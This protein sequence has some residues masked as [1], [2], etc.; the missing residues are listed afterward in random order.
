MGDPIHAVEILGPDIR[1]VHVKDARRP[2]IPG[3]WGEEVPLGQGEVDIPR[4]LRT[5]KADRLR[6]PAG[7][8]ARGRRP[9][10]ADPRRPA[11]PRPASADAW[12]SPS[13]PADAV[14]GV[15]NSEQPRT[16]EAAPRSGPA[17][18]LH[19][20]RPAWSHRQSTAGDPGGRGRLIAKGAGSMTRTQARW[21]VPAVAAL[22]IAWASPGRAQETGEKVGEKLDEVGQDIKGG[23]NRGRGRRPASSSP[24]PGP[25]STTWASSRGSTAGSTGTRRSTT[26]RSS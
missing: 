13:S 7:R 11:R 16:D 19:A 25:R 15:H 17:P 2:T 10:R 5:L 6:R 18:D 26:P 23:L 9:G 24:G 14:P 8:R 22:A 21:I 1:S 3:Q 12:P 20:D 4:F